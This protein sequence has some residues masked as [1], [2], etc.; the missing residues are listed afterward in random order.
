MVFIKNLLKGI[1]K[2]PVIILGDGR[3]KTL[4]SFKKQF[5]DGV[6]CIC[7]IDLDGK[8]ETKGMFIQANDITL[9]MGDKV[10]FMIVEME[11]WFLSQP[12][13]LNRKYKIALDSEHFKS[14]YKT[15]LDPKGFI[16]RKVRALRNDGKY[17][18]NE[19][20]DGGELLKKLDVEK[21]ANDFLDVRRLKDYLLNS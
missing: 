19:L 20:I 6:D 18:Y 4:K 8:E 1:K 21:L 9:K 15:E 12:E 17:S 16:D 2:M 11:S 14:K 5:E 13:I 10:F 7:L 3:T